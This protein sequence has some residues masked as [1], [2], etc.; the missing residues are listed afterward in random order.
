MT[1]YVQDEM[2][3]MN[4][5]F[6]PSCTL[7][8]GRTFGGRNRSRH[9][10]LWLPDS[11]PD[12]IVAT[13]SQRRHSFQTVRNVNGISFD[14]RLRALCS[15]CTREKRDAYNRYRASKY[16]VTAN[17]LTTCCRLLTSHRYLTALTLESIHRQ[18]H[19]TQLA[20]NDFEQLFL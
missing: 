18:H 20:H 12:I 6:S 3:C 10:H 2:N 7:S 8:P 5:T 16:I 9:G 11:C 15:V 13:P 14:V 17:P 19:A 1:F 4:C